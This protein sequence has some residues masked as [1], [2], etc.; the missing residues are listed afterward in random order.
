MNN[1]VVL[2]SMIRRNQKFI[3]KSASG[4]AHN[5]SLLQLPGESNC[6]NWVLGHIA[7]YRDAMLACNSQAPLLTEE[8]RR[9]YSYGSQPITANSTCVEIS[10]L[11]D[12]LNESY[13]IVSD[14]LLADPDNMLET[15][16]KY[17]DLHPDYGPSIIEN[18]G[19][20]C[21]HE[22]NHVGELHALG[23]LAEVQS[24]KLPVG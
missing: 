12:R 22:C 9:P 7:V 23:E 21:W 6:M 5:M 8:Q 18:L 13:Q 4:L 3:E 10:V 14:W 17:I 2:H 11:R 24:S 20:L 15:P 1:A 19:F 16:P